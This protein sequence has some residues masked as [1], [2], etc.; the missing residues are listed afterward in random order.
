MSDDWRER[1]RCHAQWQALSC[2]DITLASLQAFYARYKYLIMSRHI[3]SY[4]AIGALLANPDKD[5]LP[6]VAQR[7]LALMMNALALPATRGGNVNALLHICGYLKRQLPAE[8]KRALLDI[9]ERYRRGEVE[10]REPVA[11]LRAH[12]Q[13]FPDAYIEQQIFLKPYSIDE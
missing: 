5:D 4:H 2:A 12:F 11:L 1:E 8:Q 7:L 9:I 10:F 13:R 6:E 3:A